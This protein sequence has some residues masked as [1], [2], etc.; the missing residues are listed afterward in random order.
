MERAIELGQKAIALDDS[1]PAPHSLLGTIYLWNRQHEQAIA[2]AGRAVA[3]DPNFA[4]GY[5]SLGGILAF[6]GRPE[7]GIELSKKAMRLN[8]HYPAEYLFGLSV[9]YRLAGR[10]E[11]ALAPGK[12]FLALNPNSWT[13][14]FNLAIIYSEL[15]Q[16]AEA[17]A[18]V[19]RAGPISLEW[20]RQNVPFK[21]PA[22]LERHLAALRKAG[23]K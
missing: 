3:L 17:R 20:V 16:E 18:E 13:G 5:M 4:N 12:S 6:A 15:G 19:L 21:D 11:E 22:M 7:E 14:H 8:P 9:V 1:L 23:L 10:Y 2:E